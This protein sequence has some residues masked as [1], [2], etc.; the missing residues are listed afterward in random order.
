MALLRPFDLEARLGHAPTR[1]HLLP[2][3]EES[4][5]HGDRFHLRPVRLDTTP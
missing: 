4:E 2:V 3:V 5:Q 1:R